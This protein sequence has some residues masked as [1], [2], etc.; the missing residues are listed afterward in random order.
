MC[1]AEINVMVLNSG[2]VEIQYMKTHAG[3][4]N[5]LGHLN[6]SKADREMI[7][8]KIAAKVPF[9]TIL[10]DVRD[11]IC[12]EKLEQTHLL[13]KKDLFNIEQSFNLNNESV[14]HS[15]DA[16]SIEAGVKQ[17]EDSGSVLFYKPQDVQCERYPQ[18][19][20]ED[21]VLIIMNE[22]QTEMLLKVENDYI[23]TD[24]T[25]GINAYDFE[26]NTL[27]TLDEVREGFPCAFLISNRSDE[28]VMTIFF[29]LHQRTIRLYPETIRFH[30]RH[31]PDIL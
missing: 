23:C 18:L 28:E 30:V 5:D 10:D 24:G 13:T 11:S 25:H 4:T 3:H 14:R 22:G 20:K 19:R 2:T 17:M 27:V 7:A 12:N 9:Q 1:P 31:G 6:L 15:N 21:I 29:L 8:M 16:V 26:C